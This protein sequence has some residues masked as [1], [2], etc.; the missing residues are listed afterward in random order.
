MI[1]IFNPYLIM[2]LLSILVILL[3]ITRK[4]KKIDADL[5]K[6]FGKPT[7]VKEEP[8]KKAEFVKEHKLNISRQIIAS[9]KQKGYNFTTTARARKFIKN[10]IRTQTDNGITKVTL[11][12][13]GKFGTR[14][15]LFSA[16]LERNVI[17]GRVYYKSVINENLDNVGKTIKD[18]K[19]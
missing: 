9:L 16:H 18:L 7:N 12:R 4:A 11:I 6:E 5:R 19:E 15:F 17:S 8:K 2:T 14:L 10:N 13:G 1:T 3:I